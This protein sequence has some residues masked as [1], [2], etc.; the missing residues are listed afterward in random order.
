MGDG[1]AFMDIDIT[2]SS[3]RRVLL[4]DG[5]HAVEDVAGPEGR[6][7]SFQ[8]GKFRVGGAD[9]DT[10]GFS[11]VDHHTG[12]RLAGPLR[13]IKSLELDAS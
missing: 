3:V 12:K 1:R 9:A 13:C 2:P 4:A 7:S 5:W 6:A 8:V 11:F 10:L